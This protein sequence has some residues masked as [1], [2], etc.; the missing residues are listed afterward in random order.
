MTTQPPSIL[1]F[2]ELKS[3]L[4]SHVKYQKERDES[5]T[6]ASWAKALSLPQTSALTRVINGDRSPDLQVYRAFCEYFAFNSVET[7]HFKLLVIR[8]RAEGDRLLEAIFDEKFWP[9]LKA[10]SSDTPLPAGA[11]SVLEIQQGE[12][13]GLEGLA[14]AA[15]VARLLRPLDISLVGGPQVALSICVCDYQKTNAGAF[16]EFYLTVT[17]LPRGQSLVDAGAV[18]LFVRSDTPS[19]CHL[20]KAVW[21]FDCRPA[22]IEGSKP[23]VGGLCGYRISEEGRDVL[24]FEL[25][26][27]LGSVRPAFHDAAWVGYSEPFGSLSRFRLGVQGQVRSVPYQEGYD[28]YFAAENSEVGAFLQACGFQPKSWTVMTDLKAQISAPVQSFHVGNDQ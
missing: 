14:D 25:R 17:V 1:N 16:R 15:E 28:R 3:F 5:W 12:M 24:S 27:D 6:L 9:G 22:A 4:N 7:E 23:S 21:G 8:A 20:S 26:Q 13:I 11:Q 2:T 10:P 18:F 19:V